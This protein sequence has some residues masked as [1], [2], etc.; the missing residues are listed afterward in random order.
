MVTFCQIIIQTFHTVYSVM[1]KPLPTRPEQIHNKNINEIQFKTKNLL[2]TC[3]GTV[4]QTD[5]QVSAKCRD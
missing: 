4:C 5:M 1:L 3:W 2:K